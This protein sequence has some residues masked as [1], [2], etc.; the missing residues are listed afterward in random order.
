MLHEESTLGGVFAPTY[1]ENYVRQVNTTQPPFYL[2][3]SLIAWV[4]GLSLNSIIKPI[5]Q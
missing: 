2:R 5:T 1:Q 3:C 4:V